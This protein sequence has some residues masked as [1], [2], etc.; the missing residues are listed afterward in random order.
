MHD[1]PEKVTKGLAFEGEVGQAPE[2]SE[3]N[4]KLDPEVGTT[5]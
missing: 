3:G 5:S 2:G 1:K 4:L